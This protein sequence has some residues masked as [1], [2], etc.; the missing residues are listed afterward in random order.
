LRL[1]D[2]VK[3]DSMRNITRGSAVVGFVVVAWLASAP[4]LRAQA[5]PLIGRWTLDVTRSRYEPGPAPQSETRVYEA[6]G[7]MGK[8]IKASFRRVDSVGKKVTI[9]Y[10][11]MYDGKDYKYSGPDADTISLTHPDPNTLDVILKRNGHVVQRTHSV[12]SPDGKTRTQT[13]TGTNVQGQKFTVVA[14]FDR[15][16]PAT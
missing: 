7:G 14:V 5:D 1:A 16:G 10:S 12:I 11:A 4:V 3:E 15:Q 9:T 2:T 6:F 8:G 13:A